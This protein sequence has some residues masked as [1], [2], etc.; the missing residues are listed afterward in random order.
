MT[1]RPMRNA[2]KDL[3]ESEGKALLDGGEYG[4]LSLAGE[5]G[6]PYGVPLSYVYDEK[7]GALYFHGALEGKKIDL[8]RENPEAA[9]TVVTDVVRK[10]AQFTTAYRSAMAFGKVSLLTGDERRAA[11]HLFID[12]YAPDHKEAG[13]AYVDRSGE[14]T[15][16][17]KLSI[18]RISAKGSS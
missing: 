15:A 14:V 17:L 10:P 5:D 6:H 1:N 12:K 3:G 8:I 9:F 11:L 7:Q 18:D 2:K 16:L 4:V 13:S